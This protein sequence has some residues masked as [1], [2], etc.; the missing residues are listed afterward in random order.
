[1]ES[2]FESLENLAISEEC[3]NEIMDMVEAIL[4]EADGIM[5]LM[6][7]H[8]GN[9]EKAVKEW[10]KQ[11]NQE[12]KDAQQKS[13]EANRTKDGAWKSRKR[14]DMPM[15][16]NGEYSMEPF[17]K[18][19]GQAHRN[20]LNKWSANS[21]ANNSDVEGVKGKMYLPPLTKDEFKEQSKKKK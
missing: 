17:Y 18:K 14:E 7:K 20:Y 4:D 6:Q 19:D 11:R 16:V 5:P 1:M 21:H 15:H 9:K 2:I 3:F 8:K 10:V 13:T 12:L